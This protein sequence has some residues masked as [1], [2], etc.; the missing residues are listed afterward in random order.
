MTNRLL[1]LTEHPAGAILDT[2]GIIDEIR[3]EFESAA[4]VEQRVSL[5]GMYT[6]TMDI[7]ENPSPRKIAR[8]FRMLDRSTTAASSCGKHVLAQTFV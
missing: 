5:L 2:R 4:T 8:L 7:A 1:Q 6:A 3:R